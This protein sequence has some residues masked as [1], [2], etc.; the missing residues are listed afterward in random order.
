MS[1]TL[2]AVRPF[3]F[4]LAAAGLLASAGAA[5]ASSYSYDFEAGTTSPWN[6]VVDPGFPAGSYSLSAAM[7]DNVCPTAGGFYASLQNAGNFM[8]MSGQWMYARYPVTSSTLS[9]TVK[10]DWAIRNKANCPTCRAIAWIGNGWVSSSN[11]FTTMGGISTTNWTLYSQ[12]VTVNGVSAGAIGVA[13]GWKGSAGVQ[14]QSV[15]VG[16][17]CVRVTITP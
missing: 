6:G 8:P 5:Q 3:G 4:A 13:L 16:L 7:G 10:V 2:R 11:A 15:N 17:D 14:N 12:T 9:Y 1:P